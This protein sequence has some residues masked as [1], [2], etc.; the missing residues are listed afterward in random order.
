LLYPGSVKLL[1]TKA[2]RSNLAAAVQELIESASKGSSF[3]VLKRLQPFL[4]TL[5]GAMR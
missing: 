2:H 3:V 5:Y 1:A 4:L